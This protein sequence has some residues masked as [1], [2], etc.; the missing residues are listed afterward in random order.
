[1]TTLL[2][3]YTLTS[4]PYNIGQ[5]LDSELLKGPKLSVALRCPMMTTDVH[6]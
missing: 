2:K 4:R 3:P 6:R 1:M 5:K